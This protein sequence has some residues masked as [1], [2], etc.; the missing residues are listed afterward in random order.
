M[1]LTPFGYIIWKECASLGLQYNFVSVK[2]VV[3]WFLNKN[4]RNGLVDNVAFFFSS[5]EESATDL[6][7]VISSLVQV[8]MDSYSR[9]KSGFQS[10]IQKEW[11]IGGHGFLDRCNHLHQSDK[12]EVWFFFLYMIFKSLLSVRRNSDVSPE[13]LIALRIFYS[14]FWFMAGCF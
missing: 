5:V 3:L 4:F 13:I 9:T 6:C 7:C 14:T 10:L 11:V 2:P 12:E 8:M 1:G